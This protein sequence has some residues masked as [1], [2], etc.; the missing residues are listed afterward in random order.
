MGEPDLYGRYD[1]SEAV[2]LFGP[3]TE[4]R[5]LCDS[6]WVVFPDVVLCLATVGEP[7]RLSHF[8]NG[9]SFCW[10]ADKPYR[11][12]DDEHARFVPRE[13]VGPQAKGREIHLFVRRTEAA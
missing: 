3:E 12:S 11:V 1:R 7:P 9:S 10:V 13:V 4:S 5:S 6:Q 2:A 8:E